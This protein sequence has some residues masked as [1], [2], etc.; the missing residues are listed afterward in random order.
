MRTAPAP[1]VD[2][3][4]IGGKVR[5]RRRNLARV[6]VAAAVAVLVAGGVY[7]VTKIDHGTAVGPAGK[8]PQTNASHTYPNNPGPR[9]SRARTECSSARTT[10]ALRSTPTSPSTTQPGRAGRQRSGA[11][12]GEQQW[13]RGRLLASWAVRRDWMPL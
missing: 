1:D 4:I 6:G 10:P 5:Q 7:G 3:L 8:P 2:R 11:V 13:R 12:E 9:S